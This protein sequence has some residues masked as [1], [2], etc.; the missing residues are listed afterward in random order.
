MHTLWPKGS[1]LN[2]V[3]KEATVFSVN[4]GSTAIAVVVVVIDSLSH[5]VPVHVT[6]HRLTISTST[7]PRPCLFPR[8]PLPVAFLLYSF[9]SI[10]IFSPAIFP[11]RSISS[12]LRAKHCCVHLA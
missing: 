11:Q 2:D 7:L 12:F 3:S 9:Y 6:Y 5:T 10:V 4:A 1:L 8:Y